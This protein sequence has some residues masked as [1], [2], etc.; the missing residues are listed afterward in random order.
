MKVMV[1]QPGWETKMS[2][3]HIEQFNYRDI[4][5]ILRLTFKGGSVCDFHPVNPETYAELIRADCLTKA[6]H[7]TIRSGVVVGVNRG[8]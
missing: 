7:K 4:D 3:D 5:N 6:I 8:N 1:V 2:Q